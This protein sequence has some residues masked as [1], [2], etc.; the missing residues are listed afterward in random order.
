MS[1]SARHALAAHRPLGGIMRA[2]SATYA[3]VAGFVLTTTVGLLRN[4]KAPPI[5]RSSSRRPA[6]GDRQV[7]VVS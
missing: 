5:S 2:Q 6:G 3:A 4:R 7:R 1:F